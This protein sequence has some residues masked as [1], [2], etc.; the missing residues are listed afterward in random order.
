MPPRRPDLPEALRGRPFR[1][2]DARAAGLAPWQVD[3]RPVRRVRRGVYLD[4]RVELSFPLRCRAALLAMPPGAVLSHETAAELRGLPL[5]RPRREPGSAAKPVLADIHVTVQADWAPRVAGVVVHRG[6]A[7][8]RPELVHDLPITSPTRTWLDLAATLD[9]IDLIALG[10]AILHRGFVTR[11]DLDAACTLARGRRGVRAARAVL[12]HLEPRAKSPTESWLRMLLVDDGL[13][14]PIANRPV[15][16]AAGGWLA[17]PDLQYLPPPVA[18]EYEGDQHRTDK[19]QYQRDIRR[20][21]A[22]I[23]AGWELVKVVYDDLALRPDVT[24]QRVRAAL[25]RAALRSGR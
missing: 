11:A 12:E 5:A 18:I 19:R 7:E 23:A 16:D 15:F 14:R 13:P 21:E 2:S 17:E 22:L 8:L 20:D 1:L 9:R 24:V 25:E 4:D 6:G 3:C 10:D